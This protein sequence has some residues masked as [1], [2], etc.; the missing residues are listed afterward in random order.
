MLTPTLTCCSEKKEHHSSSINVPLVWTACETLS[1][2]GSEPIDHLKRIAVELRREHER[3]P[4]VPHDRKTIVD[5]TRCKN[6]RE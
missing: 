1:S 4:G 6:L 3:L 5:P 2:A